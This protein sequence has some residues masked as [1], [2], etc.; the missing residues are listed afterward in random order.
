MPEPMDG[1]LKPVSLPCCR[2]RLLVMAVGCGIRKRVALFRLGMLRLISSWVVGWGAFTANKMKKCMR[3]HSSGTQ[4]AIAHAIEDSNWRGQESNLPV[5]SLSS[6]WELYG[7]LAGLHG[8]LDWFSIE[9]CDFSNV[10]CPGAKQL[11]TARQGMA[12]N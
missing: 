6:D 4:R 9:C 5:D 2:F 8:E 3:I 7:L 10:S 1:G 11:V 12:N